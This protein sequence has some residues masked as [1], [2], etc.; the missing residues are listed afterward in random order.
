[1]N[2]TENEKRMIYQAESTG[3]AAILNELAMTCRYAPK[4]E[5]RNTAE[6]L[7][8]KPRSLPDNECTD[9]VRDI[10]K[11]Y[12]LPPGPK[13]IGEL[14]AEARQA[15]GAEKL[16]GHDIMALERFAPD[17]RH[18][19]VFDV[20]SGETTMGDK[21]DRMRLFLTEQGYRKCLEQQDKG[22]IRIRN[23]AK[24]MGGNLHYDHKDHDL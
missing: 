2:L 23:H 6:S 7:L 4:K 12:R 16:S 17:T 15:S 3:Q 19:A 10:Q 18:M 8:Q 24:V 21:G 22:H 13:T 1:M 20:L 11:N 9:L 5:T 14:L